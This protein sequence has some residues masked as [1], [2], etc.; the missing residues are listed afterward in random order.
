MTSN[1]A[2]A[3]EVCSETRS[4]LGS[5]DSIRPVVEGFVNYLNQDLARSFAIR[6]NCA[7]DMVALLTTSEAQFFSSLFQ[8]FVSKIS[9]G[10]FQGF[11]A[12]EYTNQIS[13]LE[14]SHCCNFLAKIISSANWVYYSKQVLELYQVCQS[15]SN[16]C[17]KIEAAMTAFGVT[18]DS[19]GYAVN[20]LAFGKTD[21]IT[22]EYF[23]DIIPPFSI[24]IEVEIEEEIDE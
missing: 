23:C 9:L 16:L 18:R 2:L 13:Q 4:Y 5:F 1:T 19:S 24:E 21:Y 10:G 17:S 3:R 22:L 11:A 20:T 7:T 14:T 15:N 12:P 6:G 8:D